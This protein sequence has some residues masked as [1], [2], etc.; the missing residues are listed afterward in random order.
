[1]ETDLNFGYSF[2]RSN[3]IL[4]AGS[5]VRVHTIHRRANNHAFAGT[6]QTI[7]SHTYVHTKPPQPGRTPSSRRQDTETPQRQDNDVSDLPDPQLL[8]VTIQEDFPMLN[9]ES[10]REEQRFTSPSPRAEPSVETVG[11]SPFEIAR[12]DKRASPED[13]LHNMVSVSFALLLFL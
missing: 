2:S 13:D 8:D 1:M 5:T 7:N 6:I 10:P 9:T 11:V 3:L 4:D 12:D